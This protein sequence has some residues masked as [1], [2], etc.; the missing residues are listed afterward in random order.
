MALVNHAKQQIH[1]KLVMFG[2]A[3]SGKRTSLSYIYRKLKAEY[4][5]VMKTMNIQNDKMVFFDFFPGSKSENADY[6]IHYH[7]YTV[8]GSDVASS[9]WKMLLKGA[10]GVMFVIDSDPEKM[11]ETRES[12]G[13]LVDLLAGQGMSLQA[14]PLV[15]QCNKRDIASAVSIEGLREFVSAGSVPVT[16]SVA[17]SGEGVL[18]ALFALVRMVQNH[19]GREGVD[20]IRESEQVVNELEMGEDELATSPEAD[21][22]FASATTSIALSPE[23]KLVASCSVDMGGEVLPVPGGF[24]IPLVI[25]S[26]NSYKRVNVTVAISI[27][28]EQ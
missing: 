9:S 25:R 17:T 8:T 11:A 27:D 4:R 15:L 13:L 7:L 21:T 12:V 18:E 6:A 26:D 1:A 14:T 3:G 24:R 19:L 23:E 10:D 20:L 5:G 2:P 28:Q 16:G 22:P